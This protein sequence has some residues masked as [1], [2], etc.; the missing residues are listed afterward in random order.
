MN[1]DYKIESQGRAANISGQKA[2]FSAQEML[3][4]KGL[5]SRRLD[6]RAANSH[7]CC[8]YKKTDH[9]VESLQLV[10]ECKHQD[11]GGT[12]DQKLENEIH[13][14]TLNFSDANTRFQGIK[15]IR[16][17]VILLSGKHWQKEI[18]QH[19]VENAKLLVEKF[20]LHPDTFM[21]DLETIDIIYKEQFPNYLE[22]I[23]NNLTFE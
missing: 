19:K 7:D 14:A 1:K 12:A 16:H 5:Q 10:V 13:N 2:E 15:K 4:E 22:K 17:Y 20:K 21:G 23:K 3:L 18:N 9:Y 8:R 6:Y 11:V